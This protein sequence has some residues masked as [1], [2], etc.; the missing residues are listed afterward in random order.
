MN[1][2]EK[3]VT[4]ERI[5]SV[6]Y[7]IIPVVVISFIFI[8]F[9]FSNSEEVVDKTKEVTFSDVLESSLV[10]KPIIDNGKVYYLEVLEIE[11]TKNTAKVLGEIVEAEHEKIVSELK[12]DLTV[13]L[14]INQLT[15]RNNINKVSELVDKSN[16]FNATSV[17]VN[18]ELDK[19]D[20]LYGKKIINQELFLDE[21]LKNV[22][23]NSNEII[24]IEKNNDTANTVKGN[25]GTL[26]DIEK[27]DGYFESYYIEYLTGELKEE[28]ESDI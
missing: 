14:P 3:G 21:Y 13:E 1:N 20:V 11:E 16:L 15:I 4:K 28:N 17:F 22:K 2:E 6:W 7:F 12:G 26:L 10:G 24:G 8:M 25:V 23:Y 5:Y 18:V 19:E 9:L 27:A